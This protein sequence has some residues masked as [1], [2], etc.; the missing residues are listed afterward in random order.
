ML[1]SLGGP[2]SSGVNFFLRYIEKLQKIIDT[3]IVVDASVHSSSPL[4]GKYFDFL[5]WDP[6]G[7][8]N[9]TPHFSCFP[10]ELTQQVWES[11]NEA[12]NFDP[13]QPKDFKTIWSRTRA[14]FSSCSS[15]DASGAYNTVNGNDHLGRYLSTASVVRDM[16]E[17]IE[18]HGEW[19]EKSARDLLAT[20]C[21]ATDVE[22][23]LR[24]AARHKGEEKLNYWGFSYGTDLGQHFATVQPHRVGRMVLDAVGDVNDYVQ[25]EWGA[26]LNDID[27]ITK[28]FTASCY[29][30]GPERC[31]LFDD[32][33]PS[34]VLQNIDSLLEK[35]EQDPLS[36][37]TKEGPTAISRSDVL[38][39]MFD[40]WYKPMAAF[41][42]TA[43]MLSDLSHGNGSSFAAWKAVPFRSFCS[44]SSKESDS[45]GV[46][47]RCSDGRDI[48]HESQTDFL[49]WIARMK[50]QS[51]TFA[52]LWA[53]VRMP[54]VFYT[55]RAKWRYTG[56]FG[57]LTAHPILFASQTLDPVT[58]IRNAFAASKLFP[59]SAVIESMGMGHATVAMP[60]TCT[61]KWIR[62]YFQTGELP[63]TG[64]KCE[65]DMGPF[66]DS[67]NVVQ[68]YQGR[69]DG[70]LLAALV[71]IADSWELK[72]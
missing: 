61:A 55:I 52:A 56:P 47:I 14:V 22:N 8:N 24:R 28:N 12:I 69:A 2:G 53:E 18:K 9:T 43:N 54:C 40:S 36:A 50:E 15:L 39:L 32:G 63:E 59:G 65:V 16:V 42:Q 19:R 6:R 27:K 5:S 34:Q 35:L 57:G 66:D 30:A 41:K 31:S 38:K 49:Q 29:E 67:A 17:I 71:E 25:T 4:N 10:S 3:E 48:S 62:K 11:T 68:A 23:V 33:G 37:W 26:D 13:D 58:P 70:E 60:S 7:V 44:T 20:A 51:P 64:T 72:V 1:I 45:A 21:H 46:A